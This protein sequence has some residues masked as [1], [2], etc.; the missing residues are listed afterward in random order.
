MLHLPP[1]Q[2]GVEREGQAPDCGYDN[3]RPD[4]Q[5]TVPERRIG[6][7]P[8]VI[9]GKWFLDNNGQPSGNSHCP[10]AIIPMCLAV[11]MLSS[12]AT[13][14]MAQLKKSNPTH[15]MM[16]R[17][18]RVIPIITLKTNPT[19]SP[20]FR[21]NRLSC[22]MIRNASHGENANSSLKNIFLSFC[23]V[24]DVSLIMIYQIFP[25]Q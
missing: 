21:R 22:A 16:P 19:A 17:C 2:N 13:A 23:A 14:S 25:Q 7:L 20:S 24:R 15:K 4:K 10:L 3:V 9:H 5:R 6:M 18:N 12:P 1:G 11:H 8:G